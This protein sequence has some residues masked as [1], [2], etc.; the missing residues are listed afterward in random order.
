MDEGTHERGRTS[1]D[2]LPDPEENSIML[3]KISFALVTA[4]A[5]GSAALAPAPASAHGFGGLAA[6]GTAAALATAVSAS[7]VATA[8]GPGGVT[9]IRMRASVR[10][11]A[12]AAPASPWG[13]GIPGLAPSAL[14]STCASQS[15]GMRLWAPVP[16]SFRLRWRSASSAPTHRRSCYFVVGS[17]GTSRSVLSC[18]ARE[19]SAATTGRSAKVRSGGAR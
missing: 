7:A 4:I 14:Q 5:L 2:A 13:R 8:M 19:R 6:A 3:R 16:P 11:K 17:R 12:D 9:G 18:R 1:N 15:V 10:C